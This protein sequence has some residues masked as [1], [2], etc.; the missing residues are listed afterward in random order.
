[1]PA[2]ESESPAPRSRGDGSIQRLQPE[3]RT[4]GTRRIQAELDQLGIC[5]SRTTI[6]RYGPPQLP[7]PSWR[8]VLHLH[9]AE[10]WAGDFFTV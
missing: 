5:V 4:W 7:L 6:Q 2:G 1:M 8:T 3:N 9:A 10:I